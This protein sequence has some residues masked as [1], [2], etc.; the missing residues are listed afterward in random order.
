MLGIPQFAT[1]LTSVGISD[2]AC[3]YGRSGF[4]AFG[5]LVNPQD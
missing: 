2:S 1:S 5:A 3:A 4:R